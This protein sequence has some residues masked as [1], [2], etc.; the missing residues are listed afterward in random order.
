MLGRMQSGRPT[1]TA[2]SVRGHERKLSTGS[3]L[4]DGGDMGAEDQPKGGSSIYLQTG[5]GGSIVYNVEEERR[6]RRLAR[7]RESARLRRQRLKSSV[8]V[9]EQRVSDLEGA[10][11]LM[12]EYQWGQPEQEE[13]PRSATIYDNNGNISCSGSSSAGSISSVSSSI[14]SA[15]TGTYSSSSSSSSSGSNSSGGGGGDG[16][17]SGGGSSSSHIS[18]AGG[19]GGGGGGVGSN[20]LGRL[21]RVLSAANLASRSA[22]SHLEYHAQP[23]E[24]RTAALRSLL[25]QHTHVLD[26]LQNV[27]LENMS[28]AWMR[29]MSCQQRGK[30][31][32]MDCTGGDESSRST[33]CGQDEKIHDKGDSGDESRQ[34]HH[35]RR[36]RWSEDYW[37]PSARSASGIEAALAEELKRSVRLDDLLEETSSGNGRIAAAQQLSGGIC[38]SAPSGMSSGSGVD[39]DAGG[40]SPS[41]DTKGQESTPADTDESSIPLPSNSSSSSSSDFGLGKQVLDL[42]IIRRCVAGLERRLIAILTGPGLP[43]AD[44]AYQVRSRRRSILLFFSFHIST[45]HN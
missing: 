30:V 37:G 4:S 19:G 32:G 6:A 1:G 3:S 41:P 29:E 9:Y 18:G 40:S 5:P 2:G 17:G 20:T 10:I 21:E 16:S 43:E 24:Q 42:E 12:K 23:R 7:N 31:G 11:K 44:H 15:N 28:I 8:S 13:S 26:G 14:S 22:A 35:S 39:G 33:G 34:K 36:R 45:N 25:A 38:D 27:Q